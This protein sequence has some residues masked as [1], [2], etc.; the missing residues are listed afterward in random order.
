MSEHLT[1]DERLER[2]NIA[3]AFGL[4]VA[5]LYPEMI[6]YEE[7]TKPPVD[8]WGNPIEPSDDS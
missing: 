3:L 2:M 5:I 7:P 4:S 8:D 1:Y 6:G